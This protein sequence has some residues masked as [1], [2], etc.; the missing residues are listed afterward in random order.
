MVITINNS[1]NNIE[2]IPQILKEP[3]VFFCQ[4]SSDFFDPYL[5]GAGSFCLFSQKI[6]FHFWCYVPISVVFSP[7]LLPHLSGRPNLPG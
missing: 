2:E 6:S 3:A 5:S 4:N 1:N 7:F